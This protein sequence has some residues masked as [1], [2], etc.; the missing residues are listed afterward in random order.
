MNFLNFAQDFFR[1]R[2]FY[3]VAKAGSLT[4]AAKMLN[5]TH[6]ALSVSMKT[7]EHRLKAKLLVRTIKGMKMTIDGERLFDF[8]AKMFQESEDFLKTFHEKGGELQGELKIITTALMGETI[9]THV[10]LPFLEQH[11]NLKLLILTQLGDFDIQ[12]ADAAIRT[13][14]PNRLDLE[15]KL[16]KTFHMKLYASQGYLDKFGIPKTVRDLD[17][18]RLLAFDTTKHFIYYETNWF[19]WILHV[20]NEKSKPRQAFYKITSNEGLHNA[21]VKGFG[22]AQLTKEYIALKGSRLVEVLPELEEPK[23]DM[24]FVCAKEKLRRISELY[25]Y[26]QKQLN[27]N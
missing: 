5:V 13:F 3:F 10:L 11:P 27:G 6:A 22:I 18:H 21:A 2:Q 7:L 19:N 1:L 20:G 25:Q 8:A 12:E 14:I 17:N 26:L 4:K 15:Q 23:V 24:Y 16:L 9:L